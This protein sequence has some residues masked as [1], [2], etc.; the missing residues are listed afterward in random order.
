MRAVQEELAGQVT[1]RL[2]SGPDSA[3][4]AR[5]ALDLARALQGGFRAEPVGG[6]LL[7][8]KRFVHW[9]VASSFDRQAKVV[10]ALLPALEA[11]RAELVALRREVAELK[12][13]GGG[14]S[15]PAER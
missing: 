12:L 13:R 3:D 15:P 4:P 14:G 7:P 5:Q 1:A 11:M 2:A 10:E 6:R 8:L 9:F